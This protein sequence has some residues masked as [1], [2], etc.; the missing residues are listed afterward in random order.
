VLKN[1]SGVENL[2]GL[3]SIPPKVSQSIWSPPIKVLPKG[4]YNP[5]GPIPK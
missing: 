3:K 5:I 4:F 2:K 1:E